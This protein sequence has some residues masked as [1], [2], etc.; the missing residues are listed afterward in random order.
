M[1]RIVAGTAVLALAA[2]GCGGDSTS[3]AGAGASSQEIAMQAWLAGLYDQ[4]PEVLASYE[5]VLVPELNTGQLR[6]LLA[7]RLRGGL[8][9]GQVPGA[10]R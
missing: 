5:H 4:R 3:I 8:A 10:A 6:F 2:A 7:R 1:T 9:A